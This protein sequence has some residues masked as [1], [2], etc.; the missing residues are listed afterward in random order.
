MDA[1]HVN[2]GKI[3]K[4]GNIVCLW[5]ADFVSHRTNT[6]D[7][8][9]ELIADDVRHHYQVVRTGWLEGRFYHKVVFHLQIKDNAKV[10]IL[11]NNTDLLLTD[12]LLLSGIPTSD[13]VIGFLP[14]EVRAFQGFAAA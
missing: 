12:D 2:K 9:Y 6:P 8:T 4:Y 5:L 7:A 3:K 10:W 14:V 11:V 13:I 1:T